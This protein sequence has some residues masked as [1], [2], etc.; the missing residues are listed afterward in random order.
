M[1]CILFVLSCF[2]APAQEVSHSVHQEANLNQ[3]LSVKVLRAY[4][5]HSQSKVEDLF[6][7]FQLLTDST[8]APDLKKEVI[9]N[10]YLLFNDENVSVADITSAKLETISLSQLIQKLLESKSLVFKINNESQFNH[11]TNNSWTTNYNLII[12]QSGKEIPIRLA[13]TIYFQNQTK[14]FGTNSKSI[15]STYLGEIFRQ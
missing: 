1:F 3:I 4:Q 9:D 2:W 10:I 8:L 6:S 15:Q 5:E 12:I 13:Q 7:Y 14:S 11:V